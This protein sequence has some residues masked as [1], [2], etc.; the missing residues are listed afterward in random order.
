[1]ITRDKDVI[2]TTAMAHELILKTGV[3]VL[4]RCPLSP[5]KKVWG[6]QPEDERSLQASAHSRA[7]EIVVNAAL[8][9]AATACM[10]GSAVRKCQWGCGAVGGRVLAYV[11]PGQ[12]E[13]SALKIDE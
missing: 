2:S 1:M 9:A 5:R 8:A 10:E 7:G 11:G 13:E 12:P 3:F 6:V 4:C